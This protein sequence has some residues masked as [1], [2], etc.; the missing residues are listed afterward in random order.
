MEKEFGIKGNTLKPS[1]YLRE[2]LALENGARYR[3]EQLTNGGSFKIEMNIDVVD[4][5]Q[6]L[7]CGTFEIHNLTDRYELL[8]TYFEG[9]IIGNIYP[10]TTE[11]YSMTN[12]DIIHWK[13]FPEWRGEYVY[14]P[15]SY[16][17]KKS[18][19]MYIKIKELFLLPDPRLK[20]IPGASIDGHYY[21]C[22][23][24]NLD[25]FAGHYYYK[26]TSNLISQQVLLDRVF[27][28]KSR[29]KSFSR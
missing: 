13:L 21:C 1:M 3:G 26:N 20:S 4:I 6:E 24:K 8:T 10:F 22:Y 27:P 19:F 29:S 25:C 28:R 18:N 7:I 14:K 9:E 5:Q 17:I 15:G 12:P 2:A 11:E 16:N 23:Y